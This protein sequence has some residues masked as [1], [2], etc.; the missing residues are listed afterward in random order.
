[1]HRINKAH[2]AQ[3]VGISLEVISRER[4]GETARLATLGKD[5]TIKLWRSF[6]L[7]TTIH[8]AAEKALFENDVP[9]FVRIKDDFAV[10]NDD[11]G[12]HAVSIVRS[13]S[14][15]LSGETVSIFGSQD[16]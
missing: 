12:V 2:G 9:Y 5:R 15:C 6:Q 10:Y 8:L 14:S 16:V 7:D 11:R 1:M 13:S 3:I 4:R